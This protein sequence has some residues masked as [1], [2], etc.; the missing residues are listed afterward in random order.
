MN[1]VTPNL[2][3][4]AS[5]EATTLGGAGEGPAEMPLIRQYLRIAYRWRYVFIGCVATCV[6]LGLII[7]L[8]MTPQYTADSTIEISREAEKVTNFQGMQPENNFADQE[9]YQTQYG[10]L[11]AHSLAER[12]A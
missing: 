8:L 10:L 12:V 7:T 6:V 2:R 5:V 11:K 3:D 9:F 1:L 4:G